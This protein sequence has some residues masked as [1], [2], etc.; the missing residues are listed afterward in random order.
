MKSLLAD[1]TFFACRFSF[2]WAYTPYNV[3]FASVVNLFFV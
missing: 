1:N 2:P 3:S